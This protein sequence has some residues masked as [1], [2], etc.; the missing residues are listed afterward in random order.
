[1]NKKGT[2]KII[3]MIGLGGSGMRGLAYIL[4]QKG[5]R[6]VGMD[7]QYESLV[8]EF[9]EESFELMS[10]RSFREI[11]KDC[12]TIVYTDAL[13][14]D[15]PVLLEA[16]R[17]MSKVVGYSEALGQL[18]RKY[19]TIAVAG[20]HGKSTTTAML[21]HILIKSGFDPT[22][23]IGA[24]VPEWDGRHARLGES[25]LMVVEADEYRDHFLSLKPKYAII[26]SIEY[27]H[28]DYFSEQGDVVRSFEMF[29]DNLKSGGKVITLRS[30][31]EKYKSLNW[32]NS[33]I[34]VDDSSAHNIKVGVPGEHMKLNAVLALSLAEQ[35]GVDRELALR[36]ISDY[37]GIKRRFEILGQ[38]EKM[39]IVSD[40]GHHPTEISETLKAAKEK[41]SNKKILVLFEG[42]TLDR[43]EKY[44][45]EFVDV[46]S[47]AVGVVIAPAFLP[48]GRGSETGVADK[49]LND[50]EYKMKHAG[51]DVMRMKNYDQLASMLRMQSKN[52]EV[53]IAFSAGTLDGELRK[54]VEVH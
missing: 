11:M 46:L 42:H 17:S 26:T 7:D 30:V 13:K 6:V 54:I 14:E 43:L 48:K 31:V 34:V 28:P 38:Y 32:P 29:L 4:A 39:E 45:N 52:Y 5:D 27:D 12:E 49:A 1:M 50:I 47:E 19:S 16:K 24:G 21:S 3:G 37:R 36:T 2:P 53:V 51:I 41:Y 25:E 9:N 44:K 15:N 20:T 23:V 10:E 22:V 35:V 40:Y 33:I 8:H 18:S